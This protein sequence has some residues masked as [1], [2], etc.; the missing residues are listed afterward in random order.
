MESKNKNISVTLANLPGRL[1]ANKIIAVASASTRHTVTI[2]PDFRGTT[3]RLGKRGPAVTFWE[4]GSRTRA[5]VAL[6]IAV[7]IRS[8]AAVVR[9]LDL[10]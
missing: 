3:V 5:D 10:H 6:D 2:H 8:L 1:T 7:H 9:L 4:D